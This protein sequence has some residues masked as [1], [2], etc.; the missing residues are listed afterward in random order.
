MMRGE[1]ATAVHLY[2][3]R[4]GVV[5]GCVYFCGYSFPFRPIASLLF[6]VNMLL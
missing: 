1:A 2:V 3:L 4:R 5:L 6:Q